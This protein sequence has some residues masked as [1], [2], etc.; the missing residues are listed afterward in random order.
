MTVSARA[1]QLFLAELASRQLVPE[2]LDDGGYR[3][4]LGGMTLTINL[5]NKGREFDAT[6]DETIFKHFVDTILQH[7]TILPES[8]ESA[9]AHLSFAAEPSDRAFGDTCRQQVSD[10]VSL[11]LVYLAEPGE[12]IVWMTPRMLAE[13]GVSREV[14]E[15]Y[16]ADNLA[17]LLA[18]TPIETTE[19]DGHLLGML[20]THSPLKASLIFAKN[21]REKAEP[22]LGWPLFAVIPCRDFA[23]LIPESAQALFPRIAQVV[24][25]EYTRRG[26]PISTEVFKIDSEKVEA[27][28][29]FQSPLNP[30]KGMKVINH[31]DLLTFFLPHDWEDDV[32]ADGEALSYDPE[33]EDNYLSVATQLY[34]FKSDL[35]PDTA[36]RA[37]AAIVEK[38]GVEVQDRAG[39][40]ALVHYS[41]DEGEMRTWTWAVAGPV[42]SRHL[43]LA[44]FSFHIPA[45]EADSE[46]TKRRRTM[47]GEM[48]PRA[49]FR[50]EAIQ[51]DEA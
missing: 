12:H 27:I 35:A 48:L 46:E 50:S 34:T 42:T 10:Q 24:I 18:E 25:A 31:D 2:E 36:R 44:L 3:I 16:A 13:F 15:A 29:E 7:G 37:L 8:W 22:L 21:L 17:Q 40:R 45:Q 9:C 19:V 23:Y 6:G 32:G 4:V 33:E 1:K 28:G 11:V 49:L 39:D 47:L 51:Q 20:A 14:A 30:P 5:E 26:Y 38:E 43:G 41:G